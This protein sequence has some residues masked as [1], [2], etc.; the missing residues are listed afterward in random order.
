V[1]ERAV[2]IVLDHLDE[3]RSVYVACQVIGPKAGVGAESL[4]G[5][6]LQA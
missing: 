1:R 6:V 5:W 2:K 3:D 4:R